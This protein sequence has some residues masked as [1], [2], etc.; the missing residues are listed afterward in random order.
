MLNIKLCTFC[1]VLSITYAHTTLFKGNVADPTGHWYNYA[2]NLNW[3]KLKYTAVCV[4]H[5]CCM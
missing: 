4:V 1:E 3:N 2:C 5:R